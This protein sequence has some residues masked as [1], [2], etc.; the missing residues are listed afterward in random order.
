MT[1]INFAVSL[2]LVLLLF[3]CTTR[4]YNPSYNLSFNESNVTTG[5]EFETTEEP[6]VETNPFETSARELKFVS[7]STIECGP[8]DEEIGG[9]RHCGGE[10]TVNINRPLPIGTKI[11]ACV[12]FQ[13]LSG[14]H[15]GCVVYGSLTSTQSPPGRVTFSLS[16]Q[17]GFVICPPTLT[18]VDVYALG[19]R[20]GP[21][22]NLSILATCQ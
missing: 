2:L 22:E 9:L 19:D 13:D 16:D 10:L 8:P 7:A 1:K 18:F 6:I 3:G 20:L 12:G 17:N 5:S 11:N 21:I 14:S 15:S 4:E